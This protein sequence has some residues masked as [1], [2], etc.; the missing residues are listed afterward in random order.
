MKADK[1]KKKTEDALKK[2]SERQ[3]EGKSVEGAQAKTARLNEKR[4]RKER[5][6]KEGNSLFLFFVL[7]GVA[8]LRFT[9]GL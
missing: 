4:K 9:E 7:C 3:K 8:L 1:A 6:I 5:G 2:V